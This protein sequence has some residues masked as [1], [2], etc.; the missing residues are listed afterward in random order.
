MEELKV[1]DVIKER[2]ALVKFLGNGSFGEVWLAHDNLSGRDVALKIYL[3]LDPAGVE[4]FKREYANSIDVSSPYLLTPTY[5]DMY[6]RRPFLI[7][8]YCE[9]GSSSKLVGNI[10]EDQLWHFISDVANGLAVL[11]GQSDPIVHQDIKP[12]NILVDGSG[13][14]V[15]T[16]FG[17]SKRLR[18]TM[19][20][21]SRRDVSSGAVPYM[22]PERFESNP[23]LSTSS[24]IWSLGASMYELAMGDLPFNG[25]GGAMQRNGAEMPS[26]SNAYS[27]IL[28]DIMQRCLNPDSSSR[29]TAKE[30]CQWAKLKSIPLKTNN[31]DIETNTSPIPP[32][33]SSNKVSS[34]SN[35]QIG[36]VA[37]V[38]IV[39]A[40]IFGTFLIFRGW[41]GGAKDTTA[42]SETAA[43]S[44][45]TT[46]VD[47]SYIEPEEVADIPNVPRP[48][49][50]PAK[51]RDL[52]FN[53]AG[54]PY[55]FIK[56]KDRA[57]MAS[58]KSVET[59]IYDRD[60]IFTIG[61]DHP[62]GVH[63]LV[64]AEGYGDNLFNYLEF[65]DEDAEA[66][67]EDMNL[68]DMN[69]ECNIQLTAMD[70][71]NDSECELLLTLQSD[72]FVIAKTYVFKLLPHPYRETLVKY[73]GVV[74]GQQ[75]MYVEGTNIIA[76]Y[77]SEGLYELYML[78]TNGKI[79][80]I[81]N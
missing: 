4:E 53:P 30:L 42:V 8:R 81:L 60:Y 43:V 66:F 71:N 15:I 73:L 29:P 63:A 21:Q 56:G 14:F 45:T 38:I 67:F 61:K 65:S 28:N 31:N 58:N 47:F 7:M 55:V 1:G 35:E 62:N 18:A 24:D 76:P 51:H 77:G 49:K 69:D 11:H 10:T 72:G 6:G 13:R 78:A 57:A 39:C 17:I 34:K 20:K 46:V 68:D 27:P 19:R 3:S 52:P 12:D 5:I 59:K 48:Q 36:R 41:T 37:L 75:H 44:D 70:F 9:N 32:K 79:I 25:F 80:N 16:D 54:C 50:K 33:P 74:Q 40:V 64:I 23:R 26:L 22:A 2:Y